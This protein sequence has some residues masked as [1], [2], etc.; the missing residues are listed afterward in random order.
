MKNRFGKPSRHQPWDF[1]KAGI[2]IDKEPEGKPYFCLGK[3][4]NGCY[5]L[6]SERFGV[7]TLE[8]TVGLLE[9][10]EDVAVIEVLRITHTGCP[11]NQQFCYSRRG[12]E[13]LWT[14]YIQN[15]QDLNDA[16]SELVVS[17]NP[18]LSEP[19]VQYQVLHVPGL[20]EVVAAHL[21]RLSGAEE[22]ITPEISQQAYV[23]LLREVP[24]HRWNFV[25]GVIC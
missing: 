17:Q 12:E 19:L 13:Q 8:E 18:D 3:S 1:R 24:V 21:A 14:A 7:Y 2:F 9:R 4:K 11:Y 5:G 22:N 10:R 6:F 23:Q 15:R 25:R 20:E 16:E